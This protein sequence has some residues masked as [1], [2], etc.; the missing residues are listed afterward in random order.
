MNHSSTYAFRSSSSS[1]ADQR[2]SR[3][4]TVWGHETLPV[5]DIHSKQ[6]RYVGLYDVEANQGR[7][8]SRRGSE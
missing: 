5:Q 2:A 3:W 6:C 4:N 7:S 8:Y 1:N